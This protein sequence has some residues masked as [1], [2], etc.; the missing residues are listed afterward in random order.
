MI[1]VQDIY[2]PMYTDRQHF[3]ILLTGGRGSGKSFNAATFITRLTFEEG[4]K[5]L[6]TR[7]TMTS[8]QLSIIPEFTEKIDL[9]GVGKYFN[10][11]QRDIE[12][13]RSGSSVMFRGIKV[14][15]RNQTANLKSIQGLTCF[16]CDELE[17][18]VDE[19]SYEKLMLSIRQKGI[20]NRIMLIC[21]PS[22]VNHWCYKKYIEKTHKIVEY[23]G[24][25]VQISTHPN[26][27]HIHSTYLDNIDN[28]S[29]QFLNDVR[30]I[31]EENAKKYAHIV[32]G[33]WADAVEGVIFKSFELV[34]EIPSWIKKRGRGLDFGYSID[35]TAI[36]D[37]AL[38]EN[39][40][41]LDE[42]CYKTRMLTGEIITELK[43][44]DTKVMSESADP[45]L[46]D[47]IKNAGILI[48]PVD[49]FAGSI[50]A[51]IS[52]MLEFNLKVTRRSMN[53][54]FELRNYA[55][56]KDKDGEFINKPIDKYNH[57]IDAVRYWVLGEILG[58][59]LTSKNYT[60]ED[61][62]IY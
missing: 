39:D 36:I 57:V 5:I 59:I 58:K 61:L 25:P 55:W 2:K 16:V 49:K 37:C 52:K 42:L 26:V 13:T 23:D 30:A 11:T 38:H 35:P 1:E 15:S 56:G 53:A 46:I 47:E 20:Q 34:D 9:D 43:K 12:N 32:I 19:D 29:E 60:K 33:R 44:D 24:V 8:A 4:H 22:D 40:L 17:E 41:Y 48:Y 10:V 54:I 45:R 21:N 18:W 62:G 50:N 14:S 3:I 51:G 28:L 6:Y 7:Y 31:K 27:L